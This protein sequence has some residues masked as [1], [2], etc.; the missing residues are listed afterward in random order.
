MKI[1][2]RGKARRKGADLRPS[3]YR[4]EWDW[5]SG[6]RTYKTVPKLGEKPPRDEVVGSRAFPSHV[7]RWVEVLADE[8]ILDI[9]RH[10]LGAYLIGQGSRLILSLP[11]VD[12]IRD[13]RPKILKYGDSDDSKTFR[14]FVFTPSA[15]EGKG[16]HTFHIRKTDRVNVDAVCEKLRMAPDAVA[17]VAITW[18]LTLIFRQYEDIAP[19]DV[20]AGLAADVERFKR[21]VKARARKSKRRGRELMKGRK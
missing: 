10:E 17:V 6:M 15:P 9:E 19:S 1:T 3:T 11:H 8:V 5:I 13:W 18:A 20:I 4:D 21:D 12:V 2:T 16:K 7:L 14:E